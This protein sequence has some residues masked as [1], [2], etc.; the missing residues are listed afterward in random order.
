MKKAKV[1]ASIH[2]FTCACDKEKEMTIKQLIDHAKESHGIDLEGKRG[3][4]ELMVH[5]LM[6]PRSQSTYKIECEGLTFYEH[7]R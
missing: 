7:W 2:F 3:K 4:K 5:I 6:R 1:T